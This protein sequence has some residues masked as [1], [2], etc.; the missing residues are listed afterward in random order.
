MVCSPFIAIVSAAEVIRLLC[1]HWTMTV[2]RRN[3]AQPTDQTG[4]IVNI[5]LPE[6]HIVRTGWTKM[7]SI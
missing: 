1:G 3:T 5:C 2:I 7:L 6:T 4:S